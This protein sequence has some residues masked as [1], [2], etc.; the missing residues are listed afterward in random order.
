MIHDVLH[1][2][3]AWSN[4]YSSSMYIV[5]GP[6]AHQLISNSQAKIEIRFPPRKSKQGGRTSLSSSA[7]AASSVV[8]NGR[9]GWIDATSSNKTKGA[10]KKRG[11]KENQNTL[12]ANA[13][14]KQKS[15][16]KVQ[17]E[18]F[19]KALSSKKATK[20]QPSNNQS[21]EI[22]ELDLSDDDGSTTEPVIVATKKRRRA[23]GEASRR[24]S[25]DIFDDSSSGSN[26]NEEEFEYA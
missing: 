16:R 7:T 19:A 23:S 20:T 18:R 10:A 22:I 21:K 25:R 13:N 17:G 26:D 5:P 4:P 2:K 6:K 9:G 8:S 15:N 12:N 1:P 14:A 11:K 3:V 24:K